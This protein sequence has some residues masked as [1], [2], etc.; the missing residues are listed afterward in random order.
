MLPPDSIVQAGARW[1]ALLR[2][3]PLGPAARIIRTDSR[4]TDFTATQYATALDWLKSVDAV[5]EGEDGSG[6]SP[7]AR[8]LPSQELKLFLLRRTIENESP[9]WLPDADSLV[10]DASELPGD[11]LALVSAL[12]VGQDAAFHL[13]R[14][15]HGK[16]DYAERTRIGSAG[17]L[18]VVRM[19]EA[20]WKGS[21][22]HLSK[23]DDGFGY[24]VLFRH[25]A[26]EWHLEIK[27]TTR[28]GR[29]TVHLSRNEHEVGLRDPYWRLIVVGLGNQ[30]NL[31]ALATARHEEV[32]R[33]APT[34]GGPHSKWQSVS[35]ELGA[36]D[37]QRGLPFA[38]PFD[39]A[40]CGDHFVRSSA[41][42]EWMP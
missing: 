40:I 19:L 31:R 32:L 25:G 34:D 23:I 38:M 26:H 15:I 16:V 11:A 28:Q 6:L 30:L 33:R 9:A 27:S 1:L 14:K 7:A 20:R 22:T 2:T 4:Y 10:P 37:L 21:T 18:E 8:A 35:H 29:L 41:P 36:S 39:E 24:D 3:S 13:I 12:G 5:T 42:F 17:E